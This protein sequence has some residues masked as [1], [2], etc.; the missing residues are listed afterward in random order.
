MAMTMEC[1]VFWGV[2]S[3]GPVEGHHCFEGMSKLYWN[4]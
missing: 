4:T 3:R 1:T 2:T